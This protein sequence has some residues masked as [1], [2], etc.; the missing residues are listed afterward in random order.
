MLPAVSMQD[1]QYTPG[2]ARGRN[3]FVFVQR[4][5]GSVSTGMFK[6]LRKMFTWSWF[7]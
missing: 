4:M 1:T 6:A 5:E 2:R 7:V 3:P